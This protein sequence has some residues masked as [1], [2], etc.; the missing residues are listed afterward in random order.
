[1]ARDLPGLNYDS[2]LSIDD[3]KFEADVNEVAILSR[4]KLTFG[5]GLTNPAYGV[6]DA[7]NPTN[8]VSTDTDRPLLVY[9]SLL[10]PLL[11]NVTPGQ[12][13]TLGG[14]IVANP[15]L[16]EDF[17][18]VRT[19]ENDVLVV[20][21][22]NVIVDAPPV[23][24]TRFGFAQPVRRIQ[25]PAVLN[26]ALIADYANPVLFPPNRLN[27]IV[28]LAVI[29]VANTT[30]GL[31]LQMDYT[32]SNYSFN[33]PWFSPIDVV[34][35]SYLGSGIQTT[36]NTHALSF[37]DLTNGVFTLYT[38]LLEYGLVQA[39][40]N[41]VKGVPGKLCSESI[42]QARVLTDFSGVVT[43]GSRFGG[44]GAKYIVLSRYPVLVTGFYQTNAKGRALC[45][46][47][48][49][50]TR[51]VVIPAPE[52][53]D[54]NGALIQY[55]ATQA[56][57]PPAALI[58]NTL[59]FGQANS[60]S[61][62]IYSG[63]ISHSQVVNASIP[64]DGAGPVPR[65]YSIFMNGSGG[66]TPTPQIIVP[67]LML[68][69]I[70]TAF[71]AIAFTIFG[72]SRMSL[73][74]ADANSVSS[75]SI[76][77]RVYGV[78][79][80]G[81]SLTEDLAFSGL[82]WTPVSIPG[83]E[84]P[85]QSV[86]SS[87]IF[88]GVT[89]LQVVSRTNDGPLSKVVLFAE[90]Q[91]EVTQNLNNLASAA[92]VTWDGT[93]LINLVDQRKVVHIIPEPNNRFLEDHLYGLGGSGSLSW[94]FAEDLKD[95]KYKDTTNGTDV[96]FPAVATITI[97][98]YTAIQ[99]GDTIQLPSFP[100]PKTLTPVISGVPNRAVGQFLV[101]A[102]DQTTRDDL[103][104]TVND[105]TFASG[106]SAIGSVSNTGEADL[107]ALTIGA[108]GNGPVVWTTLVFPPT[109]VTTTDAVGGIDTFGESK[110]P[111]HA[112]TLNTVL[113]PT[114]TYDVTSVQGKYISRAIPLGGGP[115]VTVL[116]HGVQP[117]YNAVQ[118][119]IRVAYSSGAWQPWQVITN[120]G[121]VFTSLQPHGVTK[122]QIELFGKC[123]G[124]SLYEGAV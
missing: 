72:P 11:I 97:N 114:S 62:I 108:R 94:V 59:I 29:K 95:P 71:Q 22:E 17:A 8:L 74:L 84:T 82:T 12:V 51:Y 36:S 16:L 104:L 103:V 38:S 65:N 64:F 19:L 2:K 123:S 26:S 21:I 106:F 124:Y 35:R 119:R 47:W 110:L 67:T 10:N 15:A 83:T 9:T 91:T 60:T 111:R 13:V 34:H 49:R 73:G 42:S 96:S 23:R 100:T 85:T 70:G 115:R 68:E 39:L 89:G 55:T 81:N 6:V 63:G 1:M 109:A 18:L 14:A 102:S 44:V 122:V 46:D 57:E 75:M 77:I 112:D 28:V 116:V 4:M 37:N 87:N 90:L 121:S 20:F 56:L 32:N 93:T 120:D 101:S 86:V 79:I 92:S 43:A 107:T 31:Q 50:G 3:L 53:V 113:P 61:E 52:Y 78:D 98:D 30:S 118:L 45:F 40:D 48:I 88:Y 58:S 25:S 69:N 66:M 24:A 27:N 105:I 41:D 7:I 99:P 54:A 5:G 117:P 33:R 80:N 76:V